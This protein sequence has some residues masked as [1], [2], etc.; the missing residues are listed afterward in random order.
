M[1]RPLT[2]ALTVFCVLLTTAAQI[3]L[4]VGVSGR[5]LQ[6]VLAAESI[7]R[8][9]FRAICDPIV[10]GGLG[11]YAASTLVWLLVLAKLDV[12]FAYPFVSLGFL[13]IA[14]Y[15]YFGLH[16]PMSVLRITGICLIFTGV[17]FVAKS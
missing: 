15:G 16:E 17:L 6:G 9:L 14:L 13:F 10:I 2:I 5:R 12:S 11:L 3:S 4:K 1:N 8:F 7:P